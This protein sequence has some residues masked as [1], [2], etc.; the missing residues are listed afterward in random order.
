MNVI[1]SNEDPVV[2]EK[3]L[4]HLNRIISALDLLVDL[5]AEPRRKLVCL[6]KLII[7]TLGCTDLCGSLSFALCSEIGLI[8]RCGKD[9]ISPRQ[10][11]S[12]E[13]W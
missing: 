3:I 9:K 4:T 11:N 12:G 7:Q 1:A 2:I 13:I 10:Q 8:W 6:R 5:K